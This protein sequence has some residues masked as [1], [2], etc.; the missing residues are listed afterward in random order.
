[1]YGIFKNKVSQ[2]Y[3]I[4]EFSHFSRQKSRV[5]SKYTLPANTAFYST[6]DGVYIYQVFE[7]NTIYRLKEKWWYLMILKVLKKRRKL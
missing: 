2:S 3:N 1:M 7:N 4:L 6:E 5:I